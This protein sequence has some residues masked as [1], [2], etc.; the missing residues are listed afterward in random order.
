MRIVTI[1][2]ALGTALVL[3][4]LEIFSVVDHQGAHSKDSSLLGLLYCST[5]SLSP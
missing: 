1:A 4:N 3:C 2:F 5:I